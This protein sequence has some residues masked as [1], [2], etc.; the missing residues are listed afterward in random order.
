MSAG[1]GDDY[2]KVNKQKYDK[3]YEA[4]FGKKNIE[5]FNKDKNAGVAQ[6]VEH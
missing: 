3:N 5:D 6:L 1:K 2:R 4:I